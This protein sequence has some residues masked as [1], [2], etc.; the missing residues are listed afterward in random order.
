[1]GP[2]Q[3]HPLL[4]CGLVVALAAWAYASFSALGFNP[5]D[6]GFILAYSRR[7]LDGQVPHRDFIALRPVGSSLLHAPVLLLAGGRVFQVDRL[8][9]LL[10]VAA[11]ASFVVDASAQAM[12]TRL[13]ALERASLV[14]LAFALCLHTAPI[15]GW[16][17][18][19]GVF[20]ASAGLWL[21]SGPP[22]RAKPRSTTVGLFLCGC[23]YLCKQ[24]FAP[25]APL[26]LVAFGEWRRPRSWGAIA[27][28]GLA[29]VLWMLAA[30]GL[31]ACVA[32]LT[33]HTE[34]WERGVKPLYDHGVGG[35]VIGWVL[36]ALSVRS[37]VLRRPAAFLVAFGF[38]G[39]AAYTLGS[40]GDFA[41]VAY[42]GLGVAAGATLRLAYDGRADAARVGL[43]VTAIGWTASISHGANSPAMASG[44]LAAF[45]LVLP[46][47]AQGSRRGWLRSVAALVVFGAAV[48]YL[49]IGLTSVR[50]K[51]IYRDAGADQLRFAVGDVLAGGAGLLTNERTYRFLADLAVAIR[52]TDH[53]EFAVLPDLAG[54]WVRSQQRNP[55]S[56]DWALH[57]ELPTPE[58]EGVVIRELD[59]LRAR[60]GVVVV[61]RVRA[62]ALGD[63]WVQLG[64]GY[65]AA[66]D[67]VYRT[68]RCPIETR[69][70]MVC[71]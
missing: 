39:F 32:Q 7:I 27:A 25:I 51:S 16:H 58:L 22:S 45:A 53:A 12:R 47:A 44:L 3:R 46:H 66:V 33:A 26:A 9:T 17:T 23:A 19:D 18:Y 10:E 28:P 69:H 56:I 64:P 20:L 49:G 43:V 8:V 37:N 35:L 21:L 4:S 41:G 42:S 40:G 14:A 34:L 38:V 29:Y 55:L 61:Q 54:Y 13:L 65:S 48:A 67:H 59:A 11:G 2:T 70:F 36:G 60:G 15:F 57:A 50:R 71:R 52:E 24:S 30:R 31:G 63:R 62:D 6:E 1:M 5:T 68:F